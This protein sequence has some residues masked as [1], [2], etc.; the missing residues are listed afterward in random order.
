MEIKPSLVVIMIIY[1]LLV[2]TTVHV[3]TIS[4]ESEFIVGGERSDLMETGEFGSDL[5]MIPESYGNMSMSDR[6]QYLNDTKG[7]EPSLI[8]KTPLDDINPLSWGRYY[9]FPNG[10]EMRIGQV[11]DFLD[12]NFDVGQAD[13]RD[14]AS[15]FFGLML[16]AFNY[17]LSLLVFNIN[18]PTFADGSQIPV[19][20]TW[21]PMLMV[22]PIWVTIVYWLFPHVIEIIKAIGGLIPLT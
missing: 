12:G 6:W 14:R 4:H 11:A 5:I 22:L 17:L 1:M 21:F 15:Q 3:F 16:D 7:G 2:Y 9:I 20:L 10:D 18:N 19:T 8:W 13:W